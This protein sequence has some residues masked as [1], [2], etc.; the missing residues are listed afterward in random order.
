METV[1]NANVILTKDRD[2]LFVNYK[3]SY[4]MTLETA[5]QDVKLRLDFQQGESFYVVTDIAN[6]KSATKES[7][8]FLSN[9]EGGLKGIKAG[10]FISGSVFSYAIFSLFLKINKPLV[11]AR[12]FN[13]K[14]Q[15]INWVHE[16]RS[17][18]TL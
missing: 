17:K 8:E 1:E 4:A 3:A 15:A 18:E 13:N 11:P 9:P 10:A 12:F 16:L 2:I 6:L 14:Q 7:R 5:I